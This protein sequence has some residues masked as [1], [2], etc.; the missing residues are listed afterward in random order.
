MSKMKMMTVI[1][2]ACI[3]MTQCT[4]AQQAVMRDGH[5]ALECKNPLP[6]PDGTHQTWRIERVDLNGSPA[7]KIPVIRG[8]HF[9][10]KPEI[11]LI[12]ADRIVYES[13][14]PKDSFDEGR[15]AVTLSISHTPSMAHKPSALWFRAP[16]LAGYFL[17]STG[18]VPVKDWEGLEQFSAC[19]SL[20]EEALSD[21][22]AAEKRFDELTRHLPPALAAAFREFQPKAAAWRALPAKPPLSPEAERQRILAENAIQ[23]KDFAA[24]IEHYESGVETQPMWPAGW[25]NLALIYAE[26]NNYADAVD[27]MKHYLELAPDAPDAKDA[28]TQMIIWEDKAAKQQ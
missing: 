25:Y 21:F 22:P 18:D 8:G 17:A 3:A 9:G 2:A 16:R 19:S 13:G 7:F 11:L 6:L 4:A 28:R 23:E 26:Q 24:A 20:V 5:P 10:K 12:A 14:N 15:A 1:V 27:R